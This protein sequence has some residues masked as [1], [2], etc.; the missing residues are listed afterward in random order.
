M[1]KK[2]YIKAVKILKNIDSK[3]KEEI[4]DIFCKFFSE[5]NPRFNELVFRLECENIKTNRLIKSLGKSI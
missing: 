3:Y 5:D 4:I 1:T 2:N